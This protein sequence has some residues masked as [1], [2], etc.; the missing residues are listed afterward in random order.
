M[1]HDHEIRKQTSCPLFVMIPG[2]CKLL[3]LVTSCD[4]MLMS[5]SMTDVHNP[6]GGLLILQTGLSSS[7]TGRWESEK[8][9]HISGERRHGLRSLPQGFHWQTATVRNL[10]DQAVPAV[11]VCRRVCVEQYFPQRSSMPYSYGQA[12]RCL[13]CWHLSPIKSSVPETVPSP[14]CLLP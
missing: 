10:Q 8:H 11:N 2:E 1:H 5:M 13:Q 3:S 4:Q 7:S 9:S 6:W 14:K 12:C